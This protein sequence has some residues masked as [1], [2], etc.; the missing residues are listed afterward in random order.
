MN[1]YVYIEDFAAGV[2]VQIAFLVI[3]FA[4]MSC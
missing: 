3:E 2:F 1:I 4:I